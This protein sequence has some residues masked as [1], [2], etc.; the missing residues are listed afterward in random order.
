MKD[1]TVTL[2]ARRGAR[3]PRLRTASRRARRAEVGYRRRRS[4]PDR[5]V[6]K[7]S[8]PCGW[9]RA[10]AL[11]E[12]L[13]GRRRPRQD[14]GP[15]PRT[16]RRRVPRGAEREPVRV[17]V[18]DVHRRR[19]PGLARARQARR[20]SDAQRT[21]LQVTTTFKNTPQVPFEDLKVEL[22]G[23]PR[24]SVTTPPSCGS[25][26]TSGIVR[27]VVGA[28]SCE[29]I[30][31]PFTITSGPNGTPCANPQPFAPGFTAQTTNVQAGAFTPLYP[32]DHPSR[33]RSGG[34]WGVGPYAPGCRG[35]ARPR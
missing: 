4:G 22:F 34:E 3:A 15:L 35:A 11:S 13:E 10:G 5:L 9:N 1:T 7:S 12:C 8:D 24:A 2:P 6:R 14:A 16:G 26:T 19:R 30:S 27:T 29:P 18:R 25:Y 31:T 32:G 21:D 23:G 20:R 17:A 28:R 33:R